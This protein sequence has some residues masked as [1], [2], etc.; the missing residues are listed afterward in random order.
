MR[1]LALLLLAACATGHAVQ[2]PETVAVHGGL[3]QP[4]TPRHALERADVLACVGL[5]AVPTPTLWVAPKPLVAHGGLLMAVYDPD[6]NA[7]IFSPFTPLDETT[8]WL[9][10]R[11]EI[12]HAA[13]GKPG[14]PAPFGL[15]ESCH[16]W[17][18]NG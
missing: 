1:A 15:A 14:H 8:Y 4:W 3:Y 17:P 18:I 16:F 5:D 10:F 2:L 11:H 9:V 13:L 6:A 7:I 12:V